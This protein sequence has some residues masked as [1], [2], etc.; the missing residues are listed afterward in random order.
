MKYLRTVAASGGLNALWSVPRVST[1]QAPVYSEYSLQ[2]TDHS[3]QMLDTNLQSLSIY[4][5]GTVFYK[6]TTLASQFARCL[7]DNTPKPVFDVQ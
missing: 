7:M 5:V 4:R 6:R 3:Y 2:T 1:F